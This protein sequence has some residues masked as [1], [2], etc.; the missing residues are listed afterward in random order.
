MALWNDEAS[1][2]GLLNLLSSTDGVTFTSLGSGLLPTDHPSVFYLADIFSFAAT[3]ARFVR[4]EA[5]NCPQPIAQAT[6]PACAIGEV[7]F[8]T[9]A[10][11]EPP[12]WIMLIA[13]FG[14][15]GTVTRRRA[16][17]LAA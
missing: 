15:T 14:L 7:A 9:A 2:I 6:F 1:G 10:V 11:P 16:I 5:S 3:S 13:G 12:S 17:A 8:R 4:F